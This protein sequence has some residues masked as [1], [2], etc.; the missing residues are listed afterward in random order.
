MLPPLDP[1]MLTLSL[2]QQVIIRAVEQQI[3]HLSREE[4]EER[5]LQMVTLAEQRLAVIKYLTKGRA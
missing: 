2:P 3:P 4:L 5:L 1:E